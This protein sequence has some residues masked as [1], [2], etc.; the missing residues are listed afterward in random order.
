MIG[1]VGQS[2]G[3]ILGFSVVDLFLHEVNEV[4]LTSFTRLDASCIKRKGT[5][6]EV[7]YHIIKRKKKLG[8]W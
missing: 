6:I 2:E 3:E 5:F 4:V 1:K 7:L 8:F